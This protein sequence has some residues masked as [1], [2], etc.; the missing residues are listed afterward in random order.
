MVFSKRNNQISFTL[1][2]TSQLKPDN[3]V[4]HLLYILQVKL[5]LLK[6]R[7]FVSYTVWEDDE[8]ACSFVKDNL[9][10]DAILKL[11]TFHYI[12]INFS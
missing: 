10:L 8:D 3:N 6:H 1:E 7:Y 4:Q 5:H 11:M 2:D 9:S 12:L